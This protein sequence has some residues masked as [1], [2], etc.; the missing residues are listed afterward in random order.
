MLRYVAIAIAVV[1]IVLG[2]LY[3][4]LEKAK[5]QARNAPKPPASGVPLT[6]YNK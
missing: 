2:L 1:G 5:E 6:P 3:Y 4:L